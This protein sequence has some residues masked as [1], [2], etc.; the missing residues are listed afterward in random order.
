MLVLPIKRNWLDMIV[1]GEKKEEYREVSDY[2]IKR[3]VHLLGESE[4]HTKIVIDNLKA[5]RIDKEC[6]V[7]LQNGYNQTESPQA[8][9]V[10]TLSI[11]KGR[12]EWGAAEGAEYFILHIKDLKEIKNMNQEEGKDQ[13]PEI[14][15]VEGEPVDCEDPETKDT[16]IMIR[17]IVQTSGICK[18][19]HQVRMIQAPEGISGEAANEQ[20]TEECDCDEAVRQREKIMRMQA[21]GEW[22]KNT[23]RDTQ[24]QT[25]LYSIE[26]T[27]EGSI[28]FVTIKIGKNTYKIDRDS[29]GMIRIRTTFRD[30]NEETF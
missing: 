6:E 2:W 23:F 3:F 29:D 15:R 28:D 14:E 8:I 21:A 5:G 20:A 10:I 24:L 9:A 27:F 12:E 4:D 1:S 19:C 25:V 18:Y 7:M 17:K 22:A 11:G 16:K 30:S 13:E 26:S